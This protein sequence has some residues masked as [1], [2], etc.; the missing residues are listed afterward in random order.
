M[1]FF[2]FSTGIIHKGHAE[3]SWVYLLGTLFSFQVAWLQDHPG[4]ELTQNSSLEEACFLVKNQ[5]T[6][7]KKSKDHGE[8]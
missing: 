5:V 3:T 6:S 7:H 1:I 4:Q 8:R 2:H